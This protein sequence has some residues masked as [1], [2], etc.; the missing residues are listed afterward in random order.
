MFYFFVIVLIE[1]LTSSPLTMC[2]PMQGQY[3]DGLRAPLL[4]HPPA[5][6]ETYAYDEDYTV[7]LGD[8]YHQQHAPLAAHF[9]SDANPGGAEPVPGAL[10]VSSRFY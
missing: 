4:L 2:S 1:F 10:A 8:W 6:N 9:V 3:V 7:A 5:G